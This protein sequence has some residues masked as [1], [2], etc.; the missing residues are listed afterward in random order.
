MLACLKAQ[1]NRHHI[2]S[3]ETAFCRIAPKLC[4]KLVFKLAA[5]FLQQDVAFL[6]LAALSLLALYSEGLALLPT[7]INSV[8]IIYKY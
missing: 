4:C 7:F 8:F 3:L 6:N 5:K 2:P 1:A